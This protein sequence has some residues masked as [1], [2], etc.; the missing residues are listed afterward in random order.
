MFAIQSVTTKIERPPDSPWSSC[1]CTLPKNSALSLT[2]SMYL[3]E[4]PVAC[5]K[6]GIVCLSMYSG[7]FEIVSSPEGLPEASTVGTPA[8]ELLVES[9]P[10]P[11]SPLPLLPHAA[12]TSAATSA[13]IATPIRTAIPLALI[14][15]GSLS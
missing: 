3:T 5:S 1:G 9:P 13:A 11:L 7:Q 4:T 12:I 2:S 6:S 14:P 10:S 8:V 15:A